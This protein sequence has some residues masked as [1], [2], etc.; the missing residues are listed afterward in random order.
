MAS[1][2]FAVQK[3]ADALLV[4]ALASHTPVSR[5]EPGVPVYDA[6]PEN[7]PYPYVR[8]GRQIQTPD[9]E[10][11]APGKQVQITLTVFS[12]FR[13]QEEVLEILSVIEATLDDAALVL[14]T[15]EAVRCDLV[16]ADTV[17]D[18]DGVTYTGS[19]IYAVLVNP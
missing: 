17:I 13:G 8:F 9:D 5:T 19:A 18:A 11:A 1:I 4:A 10:L 2:E 14:D 3:A 16:R 6:A 7:A 12:D 15:G